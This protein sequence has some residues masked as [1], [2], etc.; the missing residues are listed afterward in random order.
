MILNWRR[1]TKNGVHRH[2]FVV[3]LSGE[4][5]TIRPVDDVRHSPARVTDAV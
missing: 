4:A 1:R 3:V 2:G 5:P